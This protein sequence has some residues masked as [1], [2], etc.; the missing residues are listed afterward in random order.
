MTTARKIQQLVVITP[1]EVGTLEKICAAIREV[2]GGLSHICAS[3]L[4]Q[5]ARFM[6]NTHEPGKVRDAIEKLEYDV[7]VVEVVEVELENVT[8]SLEPIAARLSK[9]NV[10]I[11]FFY[12][13]SADG[14]K[15]TCVMATNDN[16]RAVEVISWASE[17]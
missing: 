7:E 17:D 4:G 6:L 8:G 15:A 16:D 2:E 10:D 14:K 5:D 12:G 9:A 11:E 3:T 1:N 13:T